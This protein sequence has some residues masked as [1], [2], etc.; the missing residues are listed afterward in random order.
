M[1]LHFT[2]L[3]LEVIKLVVEGKTN[4]E[5]AGDL[6]LVEGT[7]KNYLKKI[8]NKTGLKNRVQLAVYYLENL[9]KL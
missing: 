3:E 8:L 4:K 6:H 7:V 5:I 1:N 9:K 2:K